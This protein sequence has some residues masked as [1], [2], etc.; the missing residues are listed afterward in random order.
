MNE[1]EKERKEIEWK[2][3]YDWKKR[4]E[5]KEEKEVPKYES[6]EIH[7]RHTL[8]RTHNFSR[9]L[10][11]AIN[12]NL[13]QP[14]WTNNEIY[15]LETV[16]LLLLPPLP[17]FLCLCLGFRWC[18]LRRQSTEITISHWWT[19]VLSRF[20]FFL[21]VCFR[22]LPISLSLSSSIHFYL[23]IQSCTAFKVIASKTL[24]TLQLITNEEKWKL[25]ISEREIVRHMPLS[26][27]ICER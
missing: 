16:F 19:L 8:T 7:N 23:F 11:G 9:S 4:N 25:F 5:K 3:I 6:G 10:N 13:L 27:H 21:F 24:D 22:S 1:S 20:V 15:L 2:R 14:N 26:P 17:L 18:R 12:F